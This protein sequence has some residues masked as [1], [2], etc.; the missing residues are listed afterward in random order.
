[1]SRA[2]PP[3]GGRRRGTRIGTTVTD[4]DA[5]SGAASAPDTFQRHWTEDDYGPEITGSGAQKLAESGVAP[6]V[7]VARRYLTL[8]P[9]SVREDA[10]TLG[11]PTDG[12][13]KMF[14]QFRDVVG[15]RDA[16]FMPW[17]SQSDVYQAA[18]RG[19]LAHRTTHQYRPHPEGRP[20]SVDGKTQKYVNI[21]GGS[22]VMDVHPATTVAFIDDPAAILITEGLMKADSALTGLLL[23]SGATV[24][25]LSDVSG[26][27]HILRMRALLDAV[28][29]EER[30]LIVALV[31]V[32]NWHGHGDWNTMRVKDHEVWLAFDG[33]A[34]TK[35]PVWLEAS[36]MWDFVTKKHGTPKMLDLH[37]DNGSGDSVKVGLDDFLT[38]HGDWSDLLDRLTG[39]LPPRPAD[40]I[41][42]AR[43]GQWR[44]DNERL[45]SEKCEE[46]LAA[47]GSRKVLTWT[48]QCDFAAR[49]RSVEISRFVSD[50]EEASGVLDPASAQRDP[51]GRCE[52]EVSWHDAN[53]DAVSAVISGPAEILADMPSDWHRRGAHIPASVVRLPDWPPTGREW[54]SAVKR[55]RASETEEL[56]LWEHMGWVPGSSGNPVFIVGEQVVG[57]EGDE[58]TRARTRVSES[59]LSGAGG[60]GV[61]LPIDRDEARE[62]LETVIRTYLGGVWTDRRVAALVLAAALRPLVPLR[63]HTTILFW[64]TRGS[65]KSYSAESIMGFWQSSPGRWVG[66]LPGT[67]S[68]TAFSMENALARVPIWVSDD[69]AP[70]ADARKAMS[71]QSSLEAIIRAVHNGKGRGRMNADG[72]SRTRLDPRGLLVVTA[73]NAL[74]V[75]SVMDRTVQVHVGQGFLSASREPTDLLRSLRSDS[76]ACMIVTGACLQYLHSCIASEGW[77]ET[78]ATWTEM[79]DIAKFEAKSIFKTDKHA[80]RHAD[81]GGD[82]AIGLYLLAETCEHFGVSEDVRAMLQPLT[83]DVF[84]LVGDSYASQ[85]TTTPGHN[86]VKA[87]RAMLNS[88][89]AHLAAPGTAG[90]PIPVTDAVYGPVAALYNQRL[91]WVLPA[92][93][94]DRPRPSGKQV[95]YLLADKD[96][97]M[98][99][100]FDPT[101]AFTE[102]RRQHPDLIPPGSG[103]REAWHS[104][105]T[106][107]LCSDAWAR[108]SKGV[109]RA[110]DIYVRAKGFEGVPIPLDILLGLDDDDRAELA[111]L[112]KVAAAEAQAAHEIEKARKAAGTP[113]QTSDADFD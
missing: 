27:G 17:Y 61:T 16:L 50:A 64:G 92:D 9:G 46:V 38:G 112:S 89:Y 57:I 10:R 33:D 88:G 13:N 85:Q 97:R 86:I 110:P 59:T 90:V 41:A 84:R 108:K 5:A 107:D 104:A 32:G 66:N 1:M 62:A 55:N 21:I 77:A 44:I 7:A 80:T 69:L 71:E 87:L 14:S 40:A 68:D 18:Q 109:G 25:E 58:S 29:E 43:A 73:E 35:G 12:R 28:P 113:S 56:A 23:A 20:V 96:G 24:E 105:W 6:L 22:S 2:P 99:A 63:P 31:G 30:V 106:E 100:L 81:L 45:V 48:K 3:R 36:R 65:G 4:L 76:M 103:Q 75:S 95:G 79:Y 98:C 91:G 39:S 74:T 60:F 111:T 94:K 70:T 47:D 52:I 34:A 83:G 19:S 15:T 11:V 53:G 93:A 51:D 101:A 8:R 78:R 72:S 26:D 67:A 82:I 102:A 49:V 42:P 54:V 37:L